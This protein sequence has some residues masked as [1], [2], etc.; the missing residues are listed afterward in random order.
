MTKAIYICN[1]EA[2]D[3]VYGPDEQVAIDHLVDVY[4]PPQTR[5]TILANLSMLADTE[6][7]LSSWGM[8]TMDASF[9]AAAPR[10]KTV[11]YGAGSIR[12][13]MTEA[14]WERGIIVISA[15][16]ANAVPV[17]EFTLAQIMLSLKHTWYYVLETKAK[18]EYPP[19]TPTPGGYG[20]TVGLVSLG[21]IGRRVAAAL[22]NFDVQV[23]AYDPYVNK[24]EARRLHVQLC[25]LEDVF[26]RADVVSLHT[27]WLP[28][29]VG[30]IQGHHFASMKAGATFI[31][32]AR[33]AVVRE[34]EMIRVLEQRP[35]LYA[36]L[37]VTYSEP[38]E[39]ASPLYSLPNV[40]L[41]PHIAGS[42]D[43]EC[44]RMGQL[45][46]E[47]VRRY[48]AGQP[49]QWAISREKAAHAA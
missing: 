3:L 1:R 44:R 23:I 25:T 39:P 11:F 21:E 48:V 31:N 46:V 12:S 35:D 34:Q 36:V 16:S 43:R 15:Y 42:Q 28:E 45:I 38:P 13:F 18:G 10:L 20:T 37:D 7:I 49:L 29:T 26:Q 8:A 9:L 41:T 24:K 6:V 14:A 30:L 4:T 33:G 27:P 22:Q 17:A 47:E 19:L 40:V 2:F 5:E 32:T